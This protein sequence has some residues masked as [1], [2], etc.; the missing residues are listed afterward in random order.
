LRCHLT[1]TEHPH[2][3]VLDLIHRATELNVGAAGP[4]YIAAAPALMASRMRA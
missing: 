4:G 2:A 3:E 1:G